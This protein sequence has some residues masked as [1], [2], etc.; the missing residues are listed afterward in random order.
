MDACVGEMEE[1]LSL[2]TKRTK[3][4]SYVKKLA[5]ET[6]YEAEKYGARNKQ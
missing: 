2:D 1:R 5:L 6:I 4:D 3:W